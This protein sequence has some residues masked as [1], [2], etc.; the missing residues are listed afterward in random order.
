MLLTATGH[1]GP[2]S[3]DFQRYARAGSIA[4]G[5]DPPEPFDLGYLAG[6]CQSGADDYGNFSFT[7]SGYDSG[8]HLL[9]YRR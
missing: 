5:F 1:N 9:R 2:P 3:Y 4:A 7:A 6:C 8:T